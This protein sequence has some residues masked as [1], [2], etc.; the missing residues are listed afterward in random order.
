MGFNFTGV[1]PD[2]YYSINS[3][4]QVGLF[5][6]TVLPIL[7][8]SLLCVVALFFA[9]SINWPIRIVLINIYTAEICYWLGFTVLFLGFPVRARMGNEEVLSL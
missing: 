8:L 3:G 1:D 2:L 5:F 9:Y 6:I 7:I 4:V